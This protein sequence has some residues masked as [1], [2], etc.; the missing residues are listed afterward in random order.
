MTDSQHPRTAHPQRFWPARPAD[1]VDTSLCP[2]CFRPLGASV[3]GFCGLDLRTPLAARVLELGRAMVQTEAERQAVIVDIRHEAW[4]R[5]ASRPTPPDQPTVVQAWAAAGPTTTSRETAAGAIPAPGPFPPPGGPAPRD[6]ALPVSQGRA[7]VPARQPVSPQR[8]GES[9]EQ[10]RRS[11]GQILLL[12]AGVVLVSVFAIFFAI[13]AYVFATVEFRSILTGI[14]SLLVLGIAWTLRSRRLAGTAEGIAVIGVVLLLLDVW[15]IRVNR[16]FSVDRLDVWLYT[17]LA[18]VVLASILVGIARLTG[19]RAPSLSAVLV[20]PVGVFALGVGVSASLDDGAARVLLGAVAAVLVGAVELVAPVPRAERVM[21]RLGAL[22]FGVV[23]IS[24]AG[25]AF[26]TIDGGPVVAFALSAAAWCLVLLVA[27]R[28]T[29]ALAGPAWRVL[30]GLG[31][32]LA[33]GGL[34][35]SAADELATT[36]P[37]VDALRPVFLAAA[38]LVVVAVAKSVPDAARR[39]LHLVSAVMMSFTSLALLL[40]AGLVVEHAGDALSSPWFR[41]YPTGALLVGME[42]LAESTAGLGVTAVLVA[43]QLRALGAG[44]VVAIWGWGPV[45]VLSLAVIGGALTVPGVVVSIAILLIAAAV[46]LV[47][48]VWSRP[49]PQIRTTAFACSIMLAL[50]TSALATASAAVW[51]GAAL[52]TL[53]IL[54]G[55]RALVSQRR[56]PGAAA[57]GVIASTSVAVAVLGIGLVA[58]S[59]ARSIDLVGG[60]VPDGFGVAVAGAAV[61]IALALLVSRLTTVEAVVVACLAAVATVASWG[62]VWVLQNGVADVGWRIAIALSV[63]AAAVCWIG[64][65]RPEVV[66]VIAVSA[67]VPTSTVM[68][69][70]IGLWLDHGATE[71]LGV[72][73]AGGTL[74]LIAAVN[75]V[76]VARSRSVALAADIGTAVPALV[77]LFL[78]A[79]LGAPL[80]PL[81]LLI[82]AAAPTFVAFRPIGGVHPRR[83]LGW[84]GAILA[85]AALWWFL[86]DRSV[87]TVEFYSLPVAGLL[88]IVGGVSTISRTRTIEGR[89]TPLGRIQGA[90]VVVGAAAAIATLPSAFQAGSGPIGRAVVVVAIGVALLVLALV[91]LRDSW[92]LRGRTI[93]WFT[94]LAAIGPPL[95]FRVLGPDGTRAPAEILALLAGA[96]SAFLIAAVAVSLFRASALLANAAATASSIV[97]VVCASCL[98]GQGSLEGVDG[99]TWL[100]IVCATAVVAT[101]RSGRSSVV[102]AITSTVGAVVLGVTM[103]AT[104]PQVEYVSVPLAAAAIVAGAIRLA[105]DRAARSWPML[106][107]GLILLILPSLAYDFGETTLWRIIA[108]GLVAVGVLLIGVL[109]RLQAPIVI[110]ALTV[111]THG[112]AQLWPWISGLYESGYWWLWAGV[113]GVVLIV[114]AARYEQRVKNIRDARRALVALR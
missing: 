23:A 1:L 14:A 36:P 5:A 38:A 11:T 70:E 76:R 81:S 52:V 71:G 57:S 8:I 13:L 7:G 37:V 93:A 62:I 108:V 80:G 10:H 94:A 82:L 92:L 16:L 55:A 12:T 99:L 42:G 32:A 114:F 53:V 60:P 3:C 107:P 19:L 90:D 33:L 68:A 106:S 100:L 17:G 111:I 88:M 113:C 63:L 50:L 41:T 95:I 31:L 20:A 56:T 49:G 43:L 110:G 79:G 67:I 35:V 73:A 66:R 59:W 47:L 15:I 97:V 102:T 40:P 109:R 54:V 112:L 83:Q 46:A 26:R 64:R 61:L 74:G 9:P 39:T 105:R 4:Q 6:E 89:R 101:T 75:A 85:T 87:D 28:S 96:T 30:A 86:A 58:P 104:V 27:H 69:A 2:S 65:R 24:V 44:R 48:C 34:A 21:T 72:L 91:L 51:P 103:L 25:A 77:I 18:L 84:V 29:T 45:V 78:T 22:I 98:V